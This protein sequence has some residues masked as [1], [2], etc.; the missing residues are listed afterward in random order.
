VKVLVTGGGGQVAQALFRDVPSSAELA[1]LGRGDLDITDWTSLSK[2]LDRVMPAVMINTAAYTAVD[3]AES[4]RDLASKI[5]GTAV[6]LLARACAERRIR[7]IH[8]S[9]DFVFDGQKSTPYL[10]TDVPKPINVYG[11]TKLEG[12]RH[13]LA[14]SGLDYLVVRTAWVYSTVGNNFL[15]TML[16]LFSERSHVRVVADQIGTPTSASS[17]AR[18]LWRCVFDTG[19]SAILHYT[20]A[21]VAS[22]YDFAQAIFEEG[23]A[24][25]LVAKNVEIIPIRTHEYPTPALRPAFSVLEKQNTL[26]RLDLKPTHWRV[27]L[28]KTLAEFSK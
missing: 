11:A 8:I 21:G 27:G 14:Q 19:P 6:Q 9:T 1:A 28:R 2:A 13:V 4:D 7:L 15:A 5:N 18:C 10:P 22:W 20:D 12:E 24:S 16:R 3:R 17:L 23:T 26:D 25:G